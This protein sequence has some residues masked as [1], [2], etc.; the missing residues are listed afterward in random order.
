MVRSVVVQSCE[1]VIGSGGLVTT[2][3][4]GGFRIETSRVKGRVIRL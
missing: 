4:L 2:V 3:Y 1:G